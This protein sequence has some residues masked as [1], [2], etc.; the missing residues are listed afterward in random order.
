[1]A[2]EQEKTEKPAK[3]AKTPRAEKAP[4][5]ER[6]ER[7]E[8]GKKKKGEAGEA[9]AAAPA[10]AAPPETPTPPRLRE[11]Y[12]KEVVAAL[13]E[14]FH[15]GYPMQVPR[16][17]KIT[18]NVGLGE[19]I[20]NAKLLEA[21]ATELGRITGQKAVITRARKAIANF[22]LRE[23][24]SIGC[25]VTLRRERMWEFMDRLVNVALPRVRDF[26]GVSPRSFD[27][28][29][30]YTLGLREQIIFPEIDYDKVEKVHGMNITFVTT[31]RTDEEG[32]ALLSELG[33]PFRA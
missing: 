11:R 7:P 25:T 17:E 2:D 4:K 23:G 1:M 20:Q 15:Y 21:A 22:R 31:A 10:E 19:A 9:A 32:R 14:R 16:L 5:G 26:R 3:A 18:L 13:R 6:A 29:G 33:M 27:G 24:L 8:K 28:R 12:R 30:N